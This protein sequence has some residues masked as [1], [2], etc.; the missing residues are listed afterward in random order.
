MDSGIAIDAKRKQQTVAQLLRHIRERFG[1]VKV[2]ICAVTVTELVHG[3]VRA[4]TVPIRD[5]RQTFVEELKKQVPVH[6]IY[7]STAEIAGL[8]GGQ[9]ALSGI[10]FNRDCIM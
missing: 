3:I 9:M 4:N 6:P 7:D 5:R 8:L 1:E 2:S 10:T